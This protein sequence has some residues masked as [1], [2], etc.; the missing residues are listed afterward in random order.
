MSPVK[1]RLNRGLL[2]PPEHGEASW[3]IQLSRL[4]GLVRSVWRPLTPSIDYTTATII[5]YAARVPG[6][7]LYRVSRDLRISYSTVY[8]KVRHATRLRLILPLSSS[9]Y[10]VTVKG[11]IVGLVNGV[12]DD[13]VFLRCL[14][15]SWNLDKFDGLDIHD[16][17]S[18]LV[19][20][21]R[22]LALRELDVVKANICSIE[23]AAAIILRPIIG[24]LLHELVLHGHV[25]SLLK[26]LNASLKVESED[27][28]LRAI[29]A[30]LIVLQGFIPLTMVTENH[31][32]FILFRGGSIIPIAV[33]CRLRCKRFTEGFGVGCT[34]LHREVV[35]QLTSITP[36]HREHSRW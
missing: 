33:E 3:G 31:K 19:L 10:S 23:E 1:L 28:M 9:G 35:S 15:Q 29:R 14:R 5:S 20:L 17:L 11:C 7:T 2:E 12:I 26:T 24:P 16:V 25:K 21:G 30:C 8:A 4:V 32:V 22:I 13:N 34:Q 6:F 18:L 36:C 27:I